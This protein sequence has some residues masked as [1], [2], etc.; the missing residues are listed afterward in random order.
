M[1]CFILKCERDFFLFLTSLIC[2]AVSYV[3][4]NGISGSLLMRYGSLQKELFE[5]FERKDAES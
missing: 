2:H 4:S 3:D 5:D 1:F